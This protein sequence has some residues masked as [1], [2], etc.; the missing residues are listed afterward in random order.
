[1][2]ELTDSMVHA[3]QILENIGLPREGVTTRGG[4]PGPAG[5]AYC[6]LGLPASALIAPSISAFR[7]RWATS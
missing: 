2:E 1:M 3:L 7:P 6:H 5:R 4:F